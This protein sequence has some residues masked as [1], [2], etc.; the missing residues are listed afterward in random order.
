MPP[1]FLSLSNALLCLLC[2][3]QG[4]SPKSL[5]LGY[6]LKECVIMPAFEFIVNF[7]PALSAAK[8]YPSRIPVLMQKK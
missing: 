6:V 5:I 7:S 2:I 4:F 1:M 3:S 8:N